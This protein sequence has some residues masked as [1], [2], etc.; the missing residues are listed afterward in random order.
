MN[1]QSELI[2]LNDS[3]WLEKQKIAGQAVKEC[4]LSCQSLI[5][6]KIPNL[7]LKD[8]ESECENI[9]NKY[10]CSPTFL[11][12]NGFPGAI[13]TSV[14]KV[15]VHGIPTSY[16]LKDGD[17]IKIDI[18]ATFKDSIADA[19][20]TFIYGEAKSKKHI[21]MINS[22]R[23]SLQEGI[24][25]I[26]VGNRLGKVSDAIF[27][28]IKKSGFKA[29]LH[30]GGHGITKNKLHASPFVNNK[31]LPDSGIVIQPGLCITLE[32]MVTIGSNKTKVGKDGWSVYTKDVSAHFEDTIFV[33]DDKID[34]IT[35]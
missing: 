10:D 12:Y 2:I 24:N 23:K 17:I 14:N 3:I 1:L 7:S 21:D 5:E 29:I 18:G 33:H 6:S 26:K 22:C 34:I 27:K 8:I 15:I 25:H 13:C 4:L 32:P 9:I 35:N 28:T 16:K 31:A 20:R 11:N 19:A 30:Y